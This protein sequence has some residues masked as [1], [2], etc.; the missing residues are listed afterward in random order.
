MT[1]RTCSISRENDNAT[2]KL[3]HMITYVGIVNITVTNV[4]RR[5][6]NDQSQTRRNAAETINACMMFLVLKAGQTV[7]FPFQY[8]QLT[9]NSV[10]R[11]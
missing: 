5:M 3:S 6:M 8:I 2:L 10:F 11:K 7:G 4:M 9:W 1:N